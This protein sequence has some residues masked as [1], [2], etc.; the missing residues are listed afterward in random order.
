MYFG[1]GGPGFDYAV[2]QGWW[3]TRNCDGNAMTTNDYYVATHVMVSYLYGSDALFGTCSR[4]RNWANSQLF[5]WVLPNMRNQ[6]WQVPKPAKKSTFVLYT[7]WNK[8]DIISFDWV[9]AGG[10]R[11]QKL[12]GAT[13]RPMKGIKFDVHYSDSAGHIGSKVTTITTDTSGNAATRVNELPVG[14][15]VMKETNPP[16]GYEAVISEPLRVCDNFEYN[17]QL[18]RTGSNKYGYYSMNNWAYTRLN[19][20]KEYIGDTPNGT[21]TVILYQNGREYS[22]YSLKTESRYSGYNGWWSKLPKFDSTGKEYVYTVREA[23]ESNGIVTIDGSRYKVIYTGNKITNIKLTDMNVKKSWEDENNRFGMRPAKIEVELLRN[24]TAIDTKVLSA[25][26]GWACAWKDLPA[27]STSGEYYFYTVKEKEGQ[28]ASLIYEPRYGANGVIVN[29]LRTIDV[30]INKTW[31]GSNSLP[32]FI[33]LRLMNGNE[34]VDSKT[35]SPNTDGVWECTFEGVPKYDKFGNEI[36]YKI[37]EDAVPGY[38]NIVS[39]RIDEQSGTPVFDITNVSTE[40]ISVPVTKKWVENVKPPSPH[41]TSVTVSLYADGQATGRS[42]QLTQSGGWIGRFDQLPKYDKNTGKEIT[43]DVRETAVDQYAWEVTGDKT[44]GFTI[45]NSYGVTSVS[46][47]KSWTNENGNTSRRPSSVSIHLIADGKDTG[48][49]LSLN[50]AGSWRGTFSNIP[51]YNPQGNEIA[52][53]IKEDAVGFYVTSITGNQKTG[54]TVANKYAENETSVKVAKAWNDK[55]NEAEL[56][57][58][59]VVAVLKKQTHNGAQKLVLTANPNTVY[60]K[61]NITIDQNQFYFGVYNVTAKKVG[62]NVAAFLAMGK[63][64]ANAELYN[65]SMQ[66]ASNTN[67]YGLYPSRLNLNTTNAFILADDAALCNL[68]HKYNGVSKSANILRSNGLLY[69]KNPSNSTYWYPTSLYVSGSTGYLVFGTKYKDDYGDGWLWYDSPITSSTGSTYPSSLR[70]ITSLSNTTWYSGGTSYTYGRNNNTGSIYLN[71]PAGGSS[72]YPTFSTASRPYNLSFYYTNTT[73]AAQSVKVM[74]QTKTGYWNEGVKLATFTAQPGTHYYTLRTSNAGTATGQCRLDFISNN[75]AATNLNGNV[76]DLSFWDA[77][78]GVTT[79]DTGKS[80]TLNASNN[81]SGSFSSLPR[82]DTSTNAPIEYIVEEKPVEHY[83]ASIKNTGKAPNYATAGTLTQ[84]PYYSYSIT[85]TL[86]DIRDISVE[87]VWDDYDDKMGYRPSSIVVSL[88]ADGAATGQSATLSQANGWKAIFSNL[89][90]KSSSGAS[91]SYT[92]SEERSSH[93]DEPVISGSMDTGF[94][95]TNG[96]SLTD[97]SVE[98]IWND[99]DDTY[100]QRA[101]SITVHLLANGEETGKKMVLS[102]ENDWRGTFADLPMYTESNQPITY[103]VSEDDV[104]NYDKAI[105]RRDD[106][107]FVISNTLRKCSVSVS[108][109]W[110]NV[111]GST[112]PESIIVELYRNGEKI[113]EAP[114]SEESGWKHVFEDLDVYDATGQPYEYTVDEKVFEGSDR[115]MK[116]ISGNAIEGYSIRNTENIDIPVYKTWNDSNNADGIR[117]SSVTVRLLANGTESQERAP[118]VLN[119]QNDWNGTFENLPRY[120]EDGKAIKYTVSEDIVLDYEAEIAG[121][122]A[123]GFTIENTHKVRWTSLDVRKT[124]DDKDNQDNI[125][126]ASITVTLLRNG[127]EYDKA[128]LSEANA[129]EHTFTRLDLVDE[130]GSFYKYEVIEAAADVPEGYESSVSR[131]EDGTY[132]ITNTHTPKTIDIPVEKTWMS[133]VPADEIPDSVTVHLLRNGEEIDSAEI[134]PNEAGAWR[135]VFEGME[136]SDVQGNAY[137]YAVTEDP[138]PHFHGDIIGSAE[139]GFQINN[140]YTLAKVTIP[141]V[142]QWEGD[143]EANR[144]PSITVNLLRDEVIIDTV[145]LTRNADGSWS[146]EFTD[147]EFLAPD[148][149]EYQYSVT[150]E[151]VDGYETEYGYTRDGDY[152][153]LNR[154][155]LEIPVQKTWNDEDNKNGSRPS[156]INVN[157]HASRYLNA[158]DLVY[159]KDKGTFNFTAQ[160]SS[161]DSEITFDG[162]IRQAKVQVLSPEGTILSEH[163]LA[164]NGLAVPIALEIGS[165]PERDCSLRVVDADGND[166]GGH[167]GK[168]VIMDD[169]R[170][171]YLIASKTLLAENDWKAVFTGLKEC[172]NRGFPIE[173]SVSEETVLGYEATYDK[174]PDGTLTIENT[175]VDGIDVEK[176]WDVG[177]NVELPESITVHLLQNGSRYKELVLDSSTNW[178]GRFE[179]VPWRDA[180][181]KVYDYAVEEDDIVG[182]EGRVA[183]DVYGYKATITNV[184]TTQVDVEKVWEGDE[185]HAEERPSSITATLSRDA[186]ESVMLGQSDAISSWNDVLNDAYFADTALH[187]TPVK[188]SYQFANA[189]DRDIVVKLTAIRGSTAY[190]TYI[191]IASNSTT[192]DAL[193]ISEMPIA[194]NTRWTF[195]SANEWDD[196]LEETIAN[197]ELRG[198]VTMEFSEQVTST[199]VRAENE[200]KASFTELP[201][202]DARGNVYLYKVS[203]SGV[204]EGYVS[205]IESTDGRY[206]IT[207][208]YGKIDIPVEKTWID[209]DDR[210]KLRPESVEIELVANGE[211]TGD[212]LILSDACDW[213]GAFMK[214]DPRDEHGE[215]I[216]YEVR[217]SN[218]PDGYNCNISGDAENGFIVENSHDCK[219]GIKVTKVW[220]DDQDALRKRPMSITVHLFGDGEEVASGKIQGSGDVWEMVFQDLPYVDKDGHVIEYTV[221]EEAVD[222]YTMTNL[223]GNGEDGYIITNWTEQP[224]YALPLSG[225]S[226]LAIMT[227]IGGVLLIILGIVSTR[228]MRIE[229]KAIK[230]LKRRLE[231][232][233]NDD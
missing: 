216:V 30:K 223:T 214:L 102:D 69:F 201:T 55:D 59:S 108:K 120:D 204:P 206:V 128:E 118:L 71:V 117:P 91:I 4:Y 227:F 5:G 7:A 105:E 23:G 142:K 83:T 229:N 84:N 140:Q 126:P 35:V 3:P 85:N 153:I 34:E 67:T 191:T 167:V 39:K 78:S 121:S 230:E 26:T 199:Q 132:I 2:Q 177:E 231:S 63:T 159:D 72:F 25:E 62:S 232:R 212:K 189:S 97:V 1:Y 77:T 27:G 12:E 203:E 160:P 116:S 70:K 168:L 64:T 76:I 185:L 114:V 73:G 171:T 181:G 75:T 209:L 8:Q 36:D 96:L 196:V 182:F 211:P 48:K 190:D 101:S 143:E 194:S 122:D 172:D 79:T 9:S 87:K 154:K 150:E 174:A 144:P 57:P 176:I 46:V 103:S 80:I 186:S 148:G 104:A 52:Y 158:A 180:N 74:H 21:L 193:P 152:L 210:D 155:T 33:K 106:G 195:A 13:K 86:G 20:Q 95:V 11:I 54:F 94:I 124:W 28:L 217:E 213:K 14:W 89:P 92:V 219:T 146:H 50:A 192:N 93:Y 37:K 100:H 133:G 130:N 197:G 170:Y 156:S 183:F 202:K 228:R 61:E 51:K 113:S 157:L 131:N 31:I 179:N 127:V 224:E 222:G 137:E 165:I 225:S 53:T 107:T 129:W 198:T 138:V 68:N 188:M 233:S 145:Q 207:N 200:W 149:H 43:Y 10:L 90:S 166:I 82:F 141:V 162:T 42:M 173:Y 18:S 32:S 139:D 88:L 164:P 81:W 184:P 161:F 49:T 24:G 98:K 60:K 115:Y 19:W 47:T 151:P 125:R 6:T 56:R 187:G 112:P 220:D 22:R 169:A 29:K 15:Y 205:H 110:N 218:V 40:M 163:E 65:M 147:L 109:T 44:S 66:N 41:P 221:S 99:L 175:E 123:T 215:T 45:T 58:A 16:S 136:V 208:T 38:T 135:H 178:R 17:F 111:A 119:A 226:S 134:R